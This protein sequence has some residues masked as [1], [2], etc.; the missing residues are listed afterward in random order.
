MKNALASNAGDRYHFVYAARRMLDMLHPRNNLGLIV[1][2]NVTVG[3]QKKANTRDS[4]LG[5]DLTEYYGGGKSEDA[6]EIFIVQVKYSPT[7]PNAG[8][9]L[10]RLCEDKRSKS[11]TVKPGTSVMR[12][13]ANAFFAFYKEDKEL[14]IVEKVRIK[15]HS[16]QRLAEKLETQLMQVIKILEEKNDDEGETILKA[17]EGDIKSVINKLKETTNLPWRALCIFLKKWDLS[18]FGMPM[19]SVVESELFSESCSFRSDNQVYIEGLISYIQ[20]H[21][22]SNRPTKIT[23]K[24]V[25]RQLRLRE[26]D[27]FPAPTEF[28]VVEN[29]IFTGA[30][31]K[32]LKRIDSMDSGMLL[33]HG[34]SG[35][36]KST[37]LQLL[38]KNYGNGKAMVVYDCYADGKGLQGG[39]ERFPYYKCFAQ[40]TNELDGLFHTNILAC[41]RLNYEHLMRQFN[42]AILEAARV[43][44]K[45]EHKLILAFDAVDNA[46]DAVAQ[47][48]L[49]RDES[50]V[51]ILWKKI[52]IPGNC[53]F[54]VTTRSENIPALEIEGNY[55]SFE[56]EGF[57][58]DET[59]CY[60][61]N[62]WSDANDD[63]CQHVHKRTNG[64]PR[65]QDL[66]L[67]DAGKNAPQDLFA[68]VSEV[69]KES[70]FAYYKTECPKRLKD[71]R[72]GTLILAILREVTPYIT[73]NTFSKI[74]EEPEEQI[75][76]AIKNLYFGLR[77]SD[78]SEIRW[79]NHDFQDFTKSYTEEKS[80]QARQQLAVYCRDNYGTC[81]YA[82]SNLSRHFYGSGMYEQLLEWW[83]SEDRLNSRIH[84]V[85]PYEEDV[86]DDIRYSLMAAQKTGQFVEALMLMTLSAEILHGCDTFGSV[87]KN[88]PQI[89][90]RHGYL[91]R[92]LEYLK[93]KEDSYELASYY[94]TIARELSKT[95]Q[96]S[97]RAEDLIQSGT[98]IVMQEYRKERVMERGFSFENIRDIVLFETYKYGLE[99]ALKNLENNW[100]PQE[101]VYPVF[102]M[103]TNSWVSQNGE[104]IIQSIKE[105]KIGKLQEV[106]SLLGV[107]ASENANL[108]VESLDRAAETILEL[109]KNND[110]TNP[111]IEKLIPGIVENL[112]LKGLLKK[113]ASFLNYWKVPQII[114]S[115]RFKDIP[116]MLRKNAVE[117][118]LNVSVFNPGDFKFGDQEISGY[119]FDLDI[120]KAIMKR[121]F[122]ALLLRQK[123]LAGILP[124][125]EILTQIN[126]C[127]DLW[128]E[129]DWHYN[130]AELRYSY[131]D[132]ACGL[133]E[134]VIHMK[135]FYKD[136]ADQI[137]KAAGQVLADPNIKG[138][139][140]YAEVL[141][142]NA[143]YH[144]LAEEMIRLRIQEIERP[145]YKASEKVSDLLSLY[146]I[147]SRIDPGLA[148]EIF[149]KARDEAR[150]WDRNAEDCAFALLE[151][152]SQAMEIRPLKI[153][154]L[155]KLSFVFEHLQ[156]V[157]AHDENIFR[158]E[159]NFLVLADADLSYALECLKKW[160]TSNLFLFYYC[161]AFAG[162][163]ML[164]T[165]SISPSIV[166]PLVHFRCPVIEYNL[167]LFYKSISHENFQLKEANRLLPIISRYIRHGDNKRFSMNEA[168]KLYL[169]AVEKGLETH[170]EIIALQQFAKS[171][172]HWNF[173]KDDSSIFLKTQDDH[174]HLYDMFLKTIKKG[175]A[176]VMGVLNRTSI[177]KI[178]E[179]KIDEIEEI[180]ERL[181]QTLPSAK[182]AMLIDFI[183]KWASD[184]YTGVHAIGIIRKITQK[185]NLSI[186]VLNRIKE[187]FQ[188]LLAPWVIDQISREYNKKYLEVI[189][190]GNHFGKEDRLCIFLSSISKSLKELDS[191]TLYRMIGYL[192]ALLSPQQSFN[193][194]KMLLEKS[195]KKTGRTSLK[196]PS[197][198]GIEPLPALV[199]FLSDYLGHPRM[200]V[201]WEVLYTLVDLALN[202][203]ESVLPLLTEELKDN[204]HLRWMTKREWLLLIFQHLSLRIP[205]KLESFVPY[206]LEQVL[207]NEFP[208]AKIRHQAKEVLLN[209]EGNHIGVL[210]DNVLNNINKINEPKTF[211]ERDKDI[212]YEGKWK[213][214]NY[215]DVFNFNEYDTLKYWYSHLAHCF[216]M[217]RCHVS[218]IAF[219]WVVEKWGITEKKCSEDKSSNDDSSTFEETDNSQ[220]HEPTYETLH[221][222]AERHA[223]FMV[224]GELIDNHPVRFDGEREGNRWH[225]WSRS[226]LR[227]VDPALTSR[228]LNN[229]PLDTENYG[230][231]S[232]DYEMWVKKNREED[233]RKELLV[234]GEEE[235]FAVA[236]FKWGKFEEREYEANVMSAVVHPETAEAYVHLI[237][238]QEKFMDLP[239]TSCSHNTIL[240]E[241]E[242]DLA[243]RGIFIFILIMKLKEKESIKI[244]ISGPG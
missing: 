126:E 182:I 196:T 159:E 29:L 31:K 211:L 216:G 30:A 49:K 120:V 73:I 93:K 24:D 111:G 53:I 207:N 137:I 68:F 44:K 132:A 6:N 135:N 50:F 82:K 114:G 79:R 152:A 87:L 217:H 67:K 11:G 41:T 186:D 2:E 153:E 40:I 113:T 222:Y 190:K 187:S 124:D 48:P 97:E 83:L 63:L 86:L 14:T 9:T 1:M 85:A 62:V 59:H 161:I 145:G 66:L 210:E 209:I 164:N 106:Y 134:A 23:R 172:E 34:I 144:G 160:D 96:Q 54:L 199:K 74:L 194:F 123:V 60:I 143:N 104:E 89:A 231:F 232:Y 238:S 32:L 195:L 28:P 118:F 241:F 80:E 235:W 127:L 4:F 108:K 46:V 125:E 212:R 22:V 138:Y 47:S 42:K 175:P 226:N 151:T 38:S 173:D 198:K 100:R 129:R 227:G 156:K 103:V 78:K 163:G 101:K 35:T 148:E 115:A 242:T 237:E 8:W 81:D 16:N 229:P 136:T 36:G 170:P 142:K 25:Y 7:N 110:F 178:K 239:F 71:I 98:A 234:G 169:K 64:N 215:G 218:D 51:P 10:N 221:L 205:F 109:F 188:F 107:I 75:H 17:F 228:L 179:L 171:I 219:K 158:L 165:P 236:S 204:K 177:D 55:E 45:S 225:E 174:S 133:L 155:Q 244:S 65:V 92:M 72:N 180:I 33:L 102:A 84:E 192:S 220:G 183:E 149:Y 112:I 201:R 240:T 189:L 223:M 131:I 77:I 12:K 166:W 184:N 3:D 140:H 119:N 105:A 99:N 230:F 200:S 90:I 5:V 37:I 233:F 88:Y 52:T 243:N 122:P 224:A 146:N 76:K 213:K 167:E 20:D 61:R 58:S 147:A 191:G 128:K 193:V 116:S 18:S 162:Q 21:A 95:G 27:F 203:P 117:T 214:G 130:R 13:L 94:F 56:V 69:A 176:D 15:L 70:A 168:Q 197:V 26:E 57:T 208:H 185:K 154:H 19:L 139:H 39:E 91:D 121:Q 206:F 157:I 43:A 202:L 150:A 141:G 181:S